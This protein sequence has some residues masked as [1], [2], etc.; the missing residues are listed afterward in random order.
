VPKLRV[1]LGEKTVKGR[2]TTE[3]REEQLL[4]WPEEGAPSTKREKQPQKLRR[5]SRIAEIR[6][7]NLCY[8]INSE[9]G[10]SASLLASQIGATEKRIDEVLGPETTRPSVSA[11]L[12]RAV[13]KGCGLDTYWLDQQ[14][15]DP[16]VLASKIAFL[17]VG[18]RLAVE[19]VVDALIENATS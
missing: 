10:G 5:K 14:R 7:E 15:A 2:G 3:L 8:L 17:E 16:S 9:Y 18:A 11:K 4:F 6:Y 1:L 19:S 12:A 13:E